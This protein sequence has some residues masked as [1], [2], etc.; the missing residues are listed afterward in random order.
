MNF[1]GLFLGFMRITAVSNR[2]TGLLCFMRRLFLSC[3]FL[4]LNFA[5]ISRGH[6]VGVCLEWRLPWW[7]TKKENNH[8]YYVVQRFFYFHRK[9]GGVFISLRRELQNISSLLEISNKSTRFSLWFDCFGWEW[10]L[11]SLSFFFSFFFCG[12]WG[13]M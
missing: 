1:G 13:V 11:G 12:G 7:Q 10:I 8:K 5:N 6:V 9:S 3:C 2:T 4:F